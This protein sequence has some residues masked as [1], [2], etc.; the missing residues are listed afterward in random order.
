MHNPQEN[1]RLL[2]LFDKKI[3]F[4][5]R[6]Q[7]LY[8]SLFASRWTLIFL[9]ILCVL[10]IGVF[11]LAYAPADGADAG[12]YYNYAAYIAGY[13]L[14]ER[15]TN[16]SPVYPLFIYV[17]HYV[18]DSLE[19]A[20]I[21]QLGMSALLGLITYYAWRPWNALLAF[22]L[23][24]LVIGDAQTGVVF[25]FTSTEPL[26]IFLLLSVFSLAISTRRDDRIIWKPL[27][28][29]VLLML[30]SETRTVGLYLIPGILGVYA[31]YTLDLKRAAL[32]VSSTVISILLFSTVMSVLQIHQRST[33]NMIMYS[34]PLL[35]YDLF[36]PEAGPASRN[37]ASY[38]DVCDM[39]PGDRQ[40][41]VCIE[42]NFLE[43]ESAVGRLYRDAFFEMIRTDS[44][45]MIQAA[46][47]AFYNYS[48]MGGQQYQGT[49]TPADVQ[50]STTDAR[51]ERSI[52]YMQNVEW[53]A[54][55]LTESQQSDHRRVVTDFANQLC[56]PWPEN[57]HARTVTDFLAKQYKFM[58]VFSPYLIHGL[59]ILL[60]ALFP[61]ARKFWYPYCLAA[62]IWLTHAAISSLLLNVQPRYIVVTNI[63]VLFI[64]G[65][66]LFIIMQIFFRLLY[67]I[68][69]PK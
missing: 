51:I 5:D 60:I 47:T 49:L 16:V 54:I 53:R 59:L 24:V 63:M 2:F 11:I 30:I 17:T 69:S 68:F 38:L 20:I 29:G 32:A 35:E 27:L 67:T 50:C 33:T 66:L 36:D 13:D 15:A 9:L 26:Y 64:Y 58:S 21:L 28:I 31:V 14:P 6:L 45:S 41:S 48:R 62:G 8:N 7:K 1:S 43:S 19:I 34:R 12:D 55:N 65:L 56:P 57:Q 46:R 10:R 61:W 44:D 40:I 42:E 22:L 25:N 23:A 4:D 52:D 39:P 37:L 3:S 18:L